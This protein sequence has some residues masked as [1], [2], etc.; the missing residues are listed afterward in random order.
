VAVMENGGRFRE[1][2]AVAERFDLGVLVVDAEGRLQFASGGACDLLGPGEVDLAGRWA[3]LAPRFHLDQPSSFRDKVIDLGLDGATRPV[4]VEVRALAGDPEG[5]GRIGARM[6]LLKDPRRFSELD[7]D[8]LLATQVRALAYLHRVLAHDVRAPL[9]AMQLSLELLAD[10]VSED[11]GVEVGHEGGPANVGRMR[12]YVGVMREELKRLNRILQTMLEQKDT[13]SAPPSRFDLCEVSRDIEE[14]LKPQCQRQHIDLDM[15][16][17]NLPLQ[18]S[19]HRDR[20]KQA[21]I[22]IAIRG[23]EAMPDG[24]RIAM[25]ISASSGCAQVSISDSGVGLDPEVLEETFSLLHTRSRSGQG[26]GLHAARLVAESHGGD[27][28]IESGMP[29]TTVVFS[30]PTGADDCSGKQPPGVLS[31]AGS[32]GL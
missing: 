20:I 7:I 19:G 30:V 13:F 15:E 8:M 22:N 14:L 24:G 26:A 11:D 4:R 21:L 18:V 27:L 2:A 6:L 3:E 1:L 23:L 31:A 28:R 29:G 32:H 16:L 9:N 5:P 25:V 12:R 17:P 10:S